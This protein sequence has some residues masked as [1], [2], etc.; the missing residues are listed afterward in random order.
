MNTILIAVV[1]L[2]DRNGAHRV[3]MDNTSRRSL[4]DKVASQVDETFLLD[5]VRGALRIPSTSGEEEEVAHYFVRLMEGCG[6]EAE[7]QPVAETAMM[8]PSANAIGRVAGSGGK[9]SLL[10]NG[11][12]DHNPV[13]DGWTKDP[14]GGVIEDGWLYG[15]VHMKAA[16]ACY[17]AALDAVRRS[18]IELAGDVSIALVCGE[19]RGGAGTREALR[20]G[21]TADYFILGEPTDLQL[22]T[23]HSAS[24]VVKIH[25]LGKSKHFATEDVPGQ[26]GVNAV[27]QAARVVA[28]LGG[29]HRPLRSRAEGGYLTFEP[30]PGFEGLPQLNVG[31]IEGG[32]GRR[33]NKTRPAL[34]P[35]FCTITVDYRVIPGMTREVLEADLRRFLD[36]FG[37]EEP[38]FRYELEFA[39]DTFPI[40][41]DAPTD[42][43]VVRTIE[44][45]HRLVHGSDASWSTILR[46]AASDASWM[47][48]AGITG[49]IYGPTGKY[50]SR[51]DERCETADLVAATKAYAYAIAD[52]CGAH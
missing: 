11:H 43:R 15:F 39:A 18:G 21:L 2:D 50:L 12:I 40:P 37:A 4:F 26:R 14:F 31:P 51:P 10:F 47:Q 20:R 8:G 42:S 33:Y 49:L 41:F 24:R 7:L 36:G 19:L 38:D 35:D 25:I 13:S 28:A 6:I 27:E 17:V 52:I 9:P 1:A 34:F 48:E 5:A 46:F 22:A 30:R 29:S 16:D 32:I 3:E 44:E 45:A 23:A